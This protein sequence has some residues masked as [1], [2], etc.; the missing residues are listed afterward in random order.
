VSEVPFNKFRLA[1]I[2]QNAVSPEDAAVA[3]LLE[4]FSDEALKCCSLKDSE[5]QPK[6]STEGI[7]AILGENLFHII[8]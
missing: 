1:Y 6:L 3:L 7:K 5:S 8:S 2:E 4:V